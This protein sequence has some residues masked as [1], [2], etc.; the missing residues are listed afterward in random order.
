MLLVSDGGPVTAAGAFTT[1]LVKGAPLKV[2]HRNLWNGKLGAI[3]ANS[4]IANAYTGESGLEDARQMAQLAASCLGLNPSDV[5]VASTG[6]IGA[7]LPM[8]RIK[9]GIE[10]AAAELS[11][12]R[13]AGQ[14]AARAIM[15]TDT[16]PK[17][18]AVK[19]KLED[20]KTVTIAGIAKGSG[21]IQP[22]LE[23]TMLALLATDVAITPA[24]LKAALQASIERS[25]NM[26]T[27]DRETS[28]NDM[29]LAMA[30]GFAGNRRIILRRPSERFQEGLNYVT[31][32]L[33]R[34][35]AR[36]GEGA[37]RLIE[38]EVKGARSEA[39]ARLAA[40]AVAGSN[41]VKAAVFGRDP[42]WGRIITA[43]GYSGASFSPSKVT[44]VLESNRGKVTLVRSGSGVRGGAL[45]RAGELL[46]SDEVK[47]QVDL[48][49]GEGEATAWGCDLTYDYVRI[50][51]QYTT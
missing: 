38:V 1:N 16:V 11:N 34:E 48:A 9:A 49:A 4:G 2:T 32:E 6:L 5:G 39:D 28:T 50:N 30:N 8:G 23:A 51:S 15:T 43:L 12:T 41:L 35:M 37:S 33:A 46:R 44:L 42:N 20:G 40:L 10:K 25:F 3:V 17:E 47:I 13:K 22:R 24:A 21:M 29:V 45:N 31:T 14:D 36:D 27:V 7:R 26:V 18:V 19:V